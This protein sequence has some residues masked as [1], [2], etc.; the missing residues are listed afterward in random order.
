MKQ[1]LKDRVELIF[2]FL[3]PSTGHYVLPLDRVENLCMKVEVIRVCERKKQ[4]GLASEETCP[5]DGGGETGRQ[6]GLARVLSLEIP[7]YRTSGSVL[8]LGNP[9]TDLGARSSLHLLCPASLHPSPY[10]HT[11]HLQRRGHHMAAARG[12]LDTPSPRPAI[13]ADLQSARLALNP[14][15]LRFSPHFLGQGDP[16][17]WLQPL[18]LTHFSLFLSFKERSQ[19]GR[20]RLFPTKS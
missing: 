11:T 1:L 10:T 7:C 18:Y 15:A 9:C 17:L 6:L 12:G 13:E 16:T 3:S 2:N 5:G 14:Y 4:R 19:W 20:Q 8:S